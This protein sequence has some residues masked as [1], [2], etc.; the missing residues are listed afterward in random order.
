[1][2]TAPGDRTCAGRVLRDDRAAGDDERHGRAAARR[3][4]SRATARRSQHEHRSDATDAMPTQ[5]TPIV[6]DCTHA[7]Q[8]LY[9]VA[10]CRSTS[11]IIRSCTTRSSSCA[12]SARRR[13]TSA[14]RRRASACCSPPKR[15]ATC[16]PTR[17]HR[18]DAARA[19]GGRRVAAD[20]VVVPVLRAGLG[21]LDAV[22][23]LVP[24]RAGRPHRPAARRDDGGR[25]AV[26]R[27]AAGAARR[28]ASC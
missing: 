18:R 9:S 17:R 23:E 1:M 22:L 13:S 11:S 6:A 20:V 4:R 12:T 8:K 3:L 21:M 16:R 19:G 28:R 27:E 26:L 24:Q 25:V 10:P 5:S 15:C 2:A 14:A 7:V